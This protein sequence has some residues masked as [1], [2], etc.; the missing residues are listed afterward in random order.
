LSKQ[1]ER[2]FKDN[3]DEGLNCIAPTT[4]MNLEGWWRNYRWENGMKLDDL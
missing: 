1:E 2:Q 3:I 4:S